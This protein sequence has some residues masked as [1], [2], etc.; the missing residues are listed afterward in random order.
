MRPTRKT[1][2]KDKMVEDFKKGSSIIKRNNTNSY[3]WHTDEVPFL[4]TLG[5]IMEIQVQSILHLVNSSKDKSVWRLTR[6]GIFSAKLAYH[7]IFTTS[8]KA[9]LNQNTQTK[10]RHYLMDLENLC[11]PSWATISLGNILR[12]LANK[13]TS[14]HSKLHSK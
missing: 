12:R 8:D 11:L 13:Q 9:H 1:W 5:I 2:K 7:Y 6:N 14:S 10:I 3:Y 4:L